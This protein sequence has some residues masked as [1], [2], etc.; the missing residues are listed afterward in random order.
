MAEGSK[1]REGP[2]LVFNKIGG[3]RTIQTAVLVVE[4]LRHRRMSNAVHP[5]SIIYRFREPGADNGYWGAD[6]GIQMH[7]NLSLEDSSRYAEVCRAFVAGRGELR[8]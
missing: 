5:D 3:A 4:Y 2:K 1:M 7:G 8:A 6:I